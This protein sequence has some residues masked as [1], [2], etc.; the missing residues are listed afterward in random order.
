MALY[1]YRTGAEATT[2]YRATAAPVAPGRLA[3]SVISSTSQAAETGTPTTEERSA[4]PLARALARVPGEG[5][6]VRWL[7]HV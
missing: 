4:P 5:P 2:S 6:I 1:S 3:T 7:A